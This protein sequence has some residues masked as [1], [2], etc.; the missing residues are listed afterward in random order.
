[1]PYEHCVICGRATNAASP[2]CGMGYHP[3]P[4]PPAATTEVE[5][6]LMARL[7]ALEARVE[8]LERKSH[9]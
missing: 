6:R 7:V 9:D 2:S 8:A 1:M 5:Q 3:V 4:N